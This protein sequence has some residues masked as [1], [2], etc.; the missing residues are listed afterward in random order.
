MTAP[1]A[2]LTGWTASPF[3]A[4]GY[5]HDVY[6]KGEGPGVV[7]IPEMPGIHPGVLALGNH[8]VDNGFTVACPSLYGTPGAPP[9]ADLS[10]PARPHRLTPDARHLS[11]RRHAARQPSHSRRPPGARPASVR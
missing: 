6:R 8:L 4:A 5:T 11:A 1:E 3:S 7:L 10:P 9:V 2:D